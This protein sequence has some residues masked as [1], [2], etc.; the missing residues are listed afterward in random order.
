MPRLQLLPKNKKLKGGEVTKLPTSPPAPTQI[1]LHLI[2]DPQ[3][4][5]NANVITSNN[6]FYYSCRY[7]PRL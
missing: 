3:Q 4:I 5:L 7:E 6:K 1:N 2:F